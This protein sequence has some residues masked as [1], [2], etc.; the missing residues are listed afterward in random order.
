[1]AGTAQYVALSKIAIHETESRG[2]LRQYRF[3]WLGSQDQILYNWLRTQMCLFSA[4]VTE[5]VHLFS[6][7]Y[8]AS[9]AC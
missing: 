9:T 4:L 7:T 8:Q 1:M 6:P 5:W 3:G 2:V